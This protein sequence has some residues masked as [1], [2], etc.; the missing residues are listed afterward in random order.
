[1]YGLVGREREMSEVYGLLGTARLVTL[2][3]PPGS[4][5]SRLGTE[6]AARA[7]AGFP[8]GAHVVSVEA[9][10]TMGG[11]E[12]EILAA[13]GPPATGFAGDLARLVGDRRLLLVMDNCEHLVSSCAA[14]VGALTETCPGLRVLTTGRQPL[15][16]AGERIYEVAPLGVPAGDDLGSVMGSEA[17]RLLAGCADSISPG[18]VLGAADAPAAARLCRALDG[19]P[20]AIELAA[21]RLGT[22]TFGQ[23]VER[24][25]RSLDM[26]TGHVRTGHHR[27]MRATFDWSYDLLSPG[28]QLVL[29]RL[30]VF[31]GRFGPD[32]ARQVA[33]DGRLTAGGVTD[34][35][36]RLVEMSLVV[37]ETRP[38]GP[39]YRL[40]GLIRQGGDGGEGHQPRR[41]PE[42]VGEQHA[43][44]A[45]DPGGG[46]G[47]AVSSG[48]G[49]GEGT[50]RASGSGEGASEGVSKRAAWRRNISA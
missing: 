35:L 5:K 2:V 9:L 47:F 22:L 29:A 14:L 42:P 32:A 40:L 30:S 4:G 27:S 45:S 12:A 36:A 15:K 41:G 19:L 28:E 21:H 43:G 13:L 16:L 25:D 1:M 10:A 24:L 26:L 31:P 46:H 7:A 34:G 33:A 18:F 44:R 8:D 17:G 48:S 50:C 39:E 20:L 37:A 49:P 38:G 23:M 3:G 11:L 6:I